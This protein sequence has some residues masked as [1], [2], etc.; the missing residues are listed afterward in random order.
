[1]VR[2]RSSSMALGMACSKA[3]VHQPRR[4]VPRGGATGWWRTM[5]GNIGGIDPAPHHDRPVVGVLPI[6]SQKP[7]AARQGRVGLVEMNMAGA[8]APPLSAARRARSAY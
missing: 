1:M 5:P 3:V 6:S 2:K 7:G 8:L 4:Q